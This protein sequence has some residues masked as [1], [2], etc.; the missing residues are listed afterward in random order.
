MVFPPIS[1]DTNVPC[2]IA[3]SFSLPFLPWTK[4]QLWLRPSDSLA[5]YPSTFIISIIFLLP[6]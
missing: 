1:S 4:H 3:I 2:Y 5:P 6:P